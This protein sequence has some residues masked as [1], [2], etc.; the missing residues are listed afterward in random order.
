MESLTIENDLGKITQIIKDWLKSDKEVVLYR[1][2][3]SFIIKRISLHN[4]DS[5][6]T[7]E[8]EFTEEEIIREI[9][10]YRK[11]SVEKHSS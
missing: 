5:L 2:A 10:D 3:E 4:L 11:K 1:N 7:S 8:A 9:K 6:T